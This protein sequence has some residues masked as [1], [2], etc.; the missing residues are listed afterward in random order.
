MRVVDL[1]LLAHSPSLKRSLHARR[2]KPWDM[3]DLVELLQQSSFDWKDI[4]RRINSDPEQVS[5]LFN[6]DGVDFYL[7]HEVCKHRPPKYVV[8]TLLNTYEP[9]IRAKG[10]EKR[11]PIHLACEYGASPEVVDLLI[12]KFYGCVRTK[13]ESGMLPLHIACAI[14]ISHDVVDLLLIH[15]PE[16][17]TVEDASGTTAEE[18]TKFLQE[19]DVKEKILDCLVLATVYR[20]VAK[21]AVL[22]VTE[23]I[24]S[25]VCTKMMG[26]DLG[27]LKEREISAL[28]SKEVVKFGDISYSTEMVTSELVD[29]LEQSLSQLKDDTKGTRG[30]S[31]KKHAKELD[32]LVDTI[33]KLQL[34]LETAEKKLTNQ[35][36]MEKFRV[37]KLENELTEVSEIKI[38]DGEELENIYSERE[39]MRSI[40]QKTRH[41]FKLLK[42]Q[43]QN[44]AEKL[45]QKMAES[46]EASRL[47]KKN[48]T[49]RGELEKSVAMS[50]NFMAENTKLVTEVQKLRNREKSYPDRMHDLEYAV[51]KE[52]YPKSK[53]SVRSSA[54]D[55]NR[56][57]EKQKR[58]MMKEDGVD[59]RSD[60]YIRGGR[61]SPAT[62]SLKPLNRIPKSMTFECSRSE[63]RSSSSRRKRDTANNEG[64]GIR[65]LDV[66]SYYRHKALI[67][68]SI[69]SPIKQRDKSEMKD[70]RDYSYDE[71]ND[72]D[73]DN[74]KKGRNNSRSISSRGK[75]RNKRGGN[76][77]KAELVDSSSSETNFKENVSSFED[78]DSAQDRVS[79]HEREEHPSFD[80]SND[81]LHLRRC[82]SKSLERID[83][84]NDSGSQGSSLSSLFEEEHKKENDKQHFLHQ[85]LDVDLSL[86]EPDSEEDLAKTRKRIS[87]VL[88]GSSRDPNRSVHGSVAGSVK[89]E[90]D[91][92][93]S[94]SVS[95][96]G[97]LQDKM[98]SLKLNRR[99]STSTRRIP[100]Q[101]EKR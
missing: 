56:R 13:D 82:D 24:T 8:E 31:L 45:E 17:A 69:G 40:L 19:S 86:S 62:T 57:K 21:A 1:L 70:R 25:T 91:S 76:S 60:R 78:D 74:L 93:R 46:K 44:I 5:D 23:Q 99:R 54:D 18:Y 9:A 41:K 27:P 64:G 65:G 4:N 34:Q 52:K 98:E 2:S 20:T 10:P 36:S 39:K 32:E 55:S 35:R 84:A 89:R 59:S 101:L 58:R 49:L 81:D 6:N 51:R 75:V 50:Q 3:S 96:R 79:Y 22:N 28:L 68:S 42:A 83:T 77:S 100:R 38:A 12:S 90:S 85:I 61:D 73:V 29:I 33:E 67:E 14:G 71:L 15:Y 26:N 95:A 87:S 80:R 94:R 47:Q 16:G 63:A 11:L 66:A 30:K 7:L 53:D 92:R 88:V 72:L 48:H 43:N 97:R 37:K